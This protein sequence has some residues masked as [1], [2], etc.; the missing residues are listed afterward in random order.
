MHN[1]TYNI[2]DA[3]WWQTFASLKLYIFNCQ[4]K[5]KFMENLNIL[6]IVVTGRCISIW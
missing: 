1:Y 2:F 3:I 6:L 4:R 5:F